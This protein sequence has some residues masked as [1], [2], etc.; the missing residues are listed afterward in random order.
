MRGSTL[1]AIFVALTCAA[2]LTSCGRSVACTADALFSLRVTVVDATGKQICNAS[3]VATDGS[4][5]AALPVSRL[6]P[7]SCIYLGP[8]ERAGMYSIAAR[9]GAKESTVNDVKVTRDSCHVNPRQ[10]T[11]RLT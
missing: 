7:R 11:I 8:T 10:V 9:S 2:G 6:G 3:V 4:F 5:S 1:I